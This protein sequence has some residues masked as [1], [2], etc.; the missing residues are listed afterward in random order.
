MSRI[1]REQQKWCLTPFLMTVAAIEPHAQ[2]MEPIEL[3]DPELSRFTIENTNSDNFGMV[4][5]VLE[6]REP[7]GW[8]K[9]VERYGDF[10]LVV[11]FR[12]M[13]DD[14]DSGIFV[15]ALGENEFVRGWPNQSYQ[16]QLRNPIGESPFPPVGGIFRHGMANGETTYDEDLARETSRPTG[17]WQTL[18]V[19]VTGDSLSVELNDVLITRAAGLANATGFIGIQG[20]TGALEFRSLRMRELESEP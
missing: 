1:S 11:D 3:L 19:R 15:R 8:L 20:E 17:E 16:V 7:E 9:S 5:D 13:T 6:V 2:T 14:A 12:F 10:E 18:V 4:D